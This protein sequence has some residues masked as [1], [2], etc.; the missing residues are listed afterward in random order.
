M[1]HNV[2]RWIDLS[3]EDMKAAYAMY[4]SDLYVHMGF[5]CQQSVEKALKGYC[6]FKDAEV[7]PIHNL[8]K[9]AQKADLYNL[10]SNDHKSLLTQLQPLYIEA[11]YPV[12]KE[13]IRQLLTKEYSKNLLQKAE[14]LV[15]WITNLVQ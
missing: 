10:L 15:V 1:E 8:T 6:E 11:R 7:L 2:K 13:R 4:S 5:M 3:Q 14:G 12:Y 9:L